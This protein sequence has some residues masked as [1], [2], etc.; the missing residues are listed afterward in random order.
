MQEIGTTMYS[1][2]GGQMGSGGGSGGGTGPQTGGTGPKSGGP[3][4]VE[5][6][7]KEA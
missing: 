2:E 5:G 4:V 6:E 3:D 1:Q 7:F